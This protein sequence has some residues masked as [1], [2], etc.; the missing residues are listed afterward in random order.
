MRVDRIGDLDDDEQAFTH[1][2]AGRS[3]AA[4]QAAGCPPPVLLSA[5]VVDAL[6]GDVAVAVRAHVLACA[7][8]RQLSADLLE[9][10]PGI[11]MLEDARIRRRMD[12]AR[13]RPMWRVA[14]LAASVVAAAGGAMFLSNAAQL[15]MIPAA[16]EPV[17]LAAER[18][19][20]PLLVPDKLPPQLRGGALNWRASGNRYELDLAT[21][22]KP[23]QDN[24]FKAASAA[25]ERISAQYPGKAEPLL[26]L[27]ICKLLMDR[28]VEAERV[29]RR[30]G[31]LG[32][33]M[34]DDARWYL[35]VAVYQNGNRPEARQLLAELCRGSGAR[36]AE[37]CLA[38]D[39]IGEPS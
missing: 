28:P 37:A 32:G 22:L 38:H 14:A 33:P 25:L 17:R 2:E 13:R 12:R 29:L 19:Q 34:S 18:P 23:Y 20:L 35:S 5:A 24:R 3:L 7:I 8:C 4:V 9:I 39:Q 31:A 6:P 30:A 10:E 11:D 16:R 27:G 1:E 15:G 36:A 26:Y 21:A